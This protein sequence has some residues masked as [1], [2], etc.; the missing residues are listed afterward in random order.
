M[1][2]FEETVKS[3]EFLDI[4]NKIEGIFKFRLSYLID[5]SHADDLL[6]DSRL[7]TVKM[8]AKYYPDLSISNINIKIRNN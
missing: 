8:F 4:Y 5:V 7:N 2:N 3:K 1:D 6:N